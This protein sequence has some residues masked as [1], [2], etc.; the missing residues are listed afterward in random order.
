VPPREMLQMYVD[1]M[2][3]PTH[4]AQ[5]LDLINP[6]TEE[7]IAVVAAGGAMDVDEAVISARRALPGWRGSAPAERG[8]VLDAIADAYESRSQAIASLVTTENGSPWWWT[9]QEN[10]HF[11]AQIYR[12]AATVARQIQPTA[13][14]QREGKRS[15]A[16]R[17]GVGVVAAIVPWNSPQVLLALKLATALAA[18]CTVVAKPSP[19]T[20][21]DAFVLAEAFDAAGVP[22]GV[23]NIVTGAGETGEALIHHEGV[24]KVSFTGSTAVGRSI[25]SICGNKLRPVS[26]ELGGKSA[27]LILEDA[28]LGTFASLINRECIPYSGQV[29]F[30]CTRILAPRRRFTDVLE[31]VVETLASTPF[32]DPSDKT[33]VIG[34]LVSARQRDRVEQLIRSGLDDGARPVLGGNRPSDYPVGYYVAP[35]VFVD[36]QPQMRIFQEEIFGPVL[37]VLPYDDEEDGVRLHNDSH[38]GLSGMVFGRDV[39]HAT[40]V[41]MRLETGQ[42]LVNGY[43]GP[44][45]PHAAFKDSGL[46]QAGVDRLADYQRVKAVTQPSG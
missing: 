14:I 40:E 44:P 39:T 43:R 37:T 46:G 13:Q 12:Q 32:G 17:E 7:L 26:A 20:S 11:A 10:V 27:A 15:L 34:P 4:S 5:T 35:T 41:A 42:V 45:T 2:I 1:G 3:K 19:E 21:L 6:A 8:N 31:T 33:T 38:Y 24:D 30:S 18:G 16:C 29:C 36:V 23:V 28:D 9:E 22:P 25:A